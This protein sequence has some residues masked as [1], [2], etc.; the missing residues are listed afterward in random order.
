MRSLIERF[1]ATM[2]WLPVIWR[3]SH[4]FDFFYLVCIVMYKLQRME[5]TIKEN[6][7]TEESPQVAK[8]IAE[9]LKHF[10]RYID[11]HKY[12]P[13]PKEAEAEFESSGFKSNAAFRDWAEEVAAME[14]ES[15]NKA[16]NMIRD[17]GRG[18]WD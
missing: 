15:W 4:D 2:R 14:E 18:W 12:L 3:N 8:E 5:L 16:W 1:L 13:S 7:L 11:P 9:T 17:R 10:D 6:D